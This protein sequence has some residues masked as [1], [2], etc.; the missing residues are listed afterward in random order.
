MKTFMKFRIKLVI[1]LILINSICVFGQNNNEYLLDS[2]SSY[3][4]YSWQQGGS[5]TLGKIKNFYD[6]KNRL[7]QMR[8]WPTPPQNLPSNYYYSYENEK[9]ISIELI[10]GN[11][12]FMKTTINHNDM[13]LTTDS[14]IQ[15]TYNELPLKNNQKFI[16]EYNNENLKFSESKYNWYREKWNP[17]Q[18][19]SYE[20]D[21]QK[22]KT[23][24]ILEGGDSTGF[25]LSRKIIYLFDLNEYLIEKQEYNY[26]NGGWILSNTT[27]HSYVNGL[28]DARLYYVENP[29][30]HKLAKIDS[31]FYNEDRLVLE[32]FFYLDGETL[33]SDGKIERLYDKFNLLRELKNTIICLEGPYTQTTLYFYI[34]KYT[35]V[36]DISTNCLQIAPN[37][38][39]DQITISLSGINPML[40]HGVDEP[41]EIQ[42]F[43]SLGEKVLSALARHAVPLQVNISNIPKGMYFVRI[44][45]NAAKFVKM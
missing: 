28:L 12:V 43:N 11:E 14:V 7:I 15:S 13:G 40:K 17:S 38:A 42:I 16:Y 3:I 23:V 10:Q 44:G 27:Q 4:N 2:T 26:T 29:S 18:R 25:Y 24:E 33:Y 21:S 22:R 35:S 41:A 6:S 31:L 45:N 30:A 20:Y 5:S 1:L 36:V 8:S 39:S 9:L 32:K 37:P 34:P 19:I